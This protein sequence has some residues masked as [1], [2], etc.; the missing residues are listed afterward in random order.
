MIAAWSAY[1][2]GMAVIGLLVIAAV[3]AKHLVQKVIDSFKE[4]R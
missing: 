2:F 1:A 4:G 3:A